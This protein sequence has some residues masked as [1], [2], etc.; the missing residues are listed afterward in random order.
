MVTDI[1]LSDPNTAKPQYQQIRNEIISRMTAV[2]NELDDEL[3]KKRQYVFF[4]AVLPYYRQ[5]DMCQDIKPHLKAVSV[6]IPNIYQFIVNFYLSVEYDKGIIPRCST[7]AYI[8]EYIDNPEGAEYL[9]TKEIKSF[10]RYINMVCKHA[11]SDVGK[12]DYKRTYSDVSADETLIINNWLIS[13]PKGIFPTDKI[14][15][16]YG[17]KAVPRNDFLQLLRKYSN[18]TPKTKGQK[19]TYPD[20]IVVN[21]NKTFQK[22]ATHPINAAANYDF[23]S[24]AGKKHKPVYVSMLL[25][26]SEDHNIKLSTPINEYDKCIIEAVESLAVTNTVIT[27]QS[28]YRFMHGVS[29]DAR[30]KGSQK[31]IQEIEKAIDKMMSINIKI[32]YTEHMI[33]KG[34]SKK[35]DI[36]ITKGHLLLLEQNE[37]TV[38]GQ[39][40]TIY[41]YLKPSPLYEYA[42]K[43]GHIF[44]MPI[45]YFQFPF[46]VEK[47]TAIIANYLLRRIVQAKNHDFSSKTDNIITLDA[48]LEAIGEPDPTVK[49]LRNIR[50]TVK[51]VLQYWSFGKLP[52]APEPPNQ[53]MLDTRCIVDFNTIKDKRGKETKYEIIPRCV[54]I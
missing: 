27:P 18:S 4:Y 21:T 43:V 40:T 22:I 26:L 2:L 50:E 34:L 52:D 10:N 5:L 24:K 12:K 16:L 53:N 36:H 19:I 49:T 44:T 7:K 25:E 45:E 20:N 30:K 47:R 15:S 37:D 31:C 46:R 9:T 35:G 32:D 28:I 48:I 14:R 17:E 11:L 13:E 3:F 23:G 39:K 8:D 6:Y 54:E 41:T 42:R 51:K 33:Y 1:L 38:N 29:D